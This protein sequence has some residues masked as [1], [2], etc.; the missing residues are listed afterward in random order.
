MPVPLL[1]CVLAIGAASPVEGQS[2]TTPGSATPL[3]FGV[4]YGERGWIAYIEDPTTK[5]VTA[6]RVG[7]A[8]AGRT[9]VRIEDERVVLAGPD[10]TLEIR[11]SD[12]KPGAPR[13]P[14]RR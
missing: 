5:S 12:E 7:D 10:G 2:T 9:I 1:I 14:A 4:I 3:L 6:Y 13:P 8:V 11:L